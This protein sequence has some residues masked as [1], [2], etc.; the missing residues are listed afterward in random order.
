MLSEVRRKQI[1]SA[2]GNGSLE[3]RR[4]NDVGVRED[5]C[6]RNAFEETRENRI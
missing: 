5:H 1:L 3:N 6:Q 2:D 4:F